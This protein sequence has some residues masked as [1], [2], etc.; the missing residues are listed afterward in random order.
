MSWEICAIYPIV[1]HHQDFH[2]VEGIEDGLFDE[3]P[4]LEV[5]PQP[6]KEGVDV[7]VQMDALELVQLLSLGQCFTDMLQKDA[8]EQFD[9]L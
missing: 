3:R 1:E 2:R 7:V 9:L 6:I 5:S 4:S 8:E